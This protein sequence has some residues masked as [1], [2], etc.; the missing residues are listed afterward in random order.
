MCP[1]AAY[2]AHLPNR[3]RYQP[4]LSCS[5]TCD[6]IVCACVTHSNSKKRF[7]GG[8]DTAPTNEYMFAIMVSGRRHLALVSVDRLLFSR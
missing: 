3:N 4:S 8:V 7:G 5:S 6:I 2:D 1:I